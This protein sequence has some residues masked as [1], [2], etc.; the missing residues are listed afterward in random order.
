MTENKNIF[1]TNIII[2]DIVVKY[3]HQSTLYSIFSVNYVNRM[4]PM[5][6]RWEY[7]MV[8]YYI[9][10]KYQQRNLIIYMEVAIRRYRRDF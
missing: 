4:V 5:L 1:T 8:A 3:T 2:H 9:Y 10:R 6:P 7:G